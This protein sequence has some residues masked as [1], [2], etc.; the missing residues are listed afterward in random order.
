MRMRSLKK[1]GGWWQFASLALGIYEIGQTQGNA[2]AALSANQ[3]TEQTNLR[4]LEEETTEELRRMESSQE[5]LRG[6]VEARIAASGLT[7]DSA[8][9]ESYREELESEYK[10]RRRFVQRQADL[11][12]DKI[13]GDARAARAAIRGGRDRSIFGSVGRSLG[14]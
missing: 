10:N 3:Y 9:F 6:E 5:Q 14:L 4:I 13:K 12:A 2:N 8:T 1:Q 11:G 7:S